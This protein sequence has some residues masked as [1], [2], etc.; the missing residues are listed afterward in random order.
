MTSS[1]AKI[2]A[3]PGQGETAGK[4]QPSVD[5]Q[6]NTR[7][8]ADP[9]LEL[10]LEDIA[11]S[12]ALHAQAELRLKNMMAEISL[13]RAENRWQEIIDLFYPLDQKEPEIVR[14]GLDLDLRSEVAFCLTQLKR[15]DEAI[16]QYELCLIQAPESFKLHSALGFT[17]YSSLLAAKNREILLPPQDKKI[18]IQKANEHFLKAESI[19]PDGVTSFYRHGML[20]KNIQGDLNA[21]VSL[22]Q[23]AVANWRAYSP[24]TKKERHQEHKN[25]VKSLYALASCSMK[26]DH[27]SRALSILEACLEEDKGY[28]H[29]KPHHKA[30]AM[31]KVLYHLGRNA[32]AAKA[33]EQAGS[34]S[35]QEDNDFIYELAARVQLALGSPEKAMGL[36]ERIPQ[37]KRRHYVRWTEADVL[38][39]MGKREAAKALLRRSADKDRRSK[40]RALIRLVKLAFMDGNYDEVIALAS[41]STAF[42]IETYTTPDADALFW[43][44]AA[45]L[46]LGD[47][48]EA[49]RT[50]DELAAFKPSFPHLSKLRMEIDRR[51]GKP[52]G[53]VCHIRS[54]G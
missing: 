41:E 20:C 22:L 24:E 32:E 5:Y 44:A 18:R 2:I 4:P 42:H 34:L 45:Q 28:D 43:K 16:H 15:F 49:R 8:S 9:G 26:M 11:G 39:K 51:A 35:G 31:G 30:F 19:R 37:N 13:L 38:L 6:E 3:Y 7:T 27:P 47:I 46:R 36:I 50:A 40:H 29:I 21:A 12:S 23:K 25:F 10:T 52:S 1:P 17:F 54:D 53:Q 48:E 33:L 14:L